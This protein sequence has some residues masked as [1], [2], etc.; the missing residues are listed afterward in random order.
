MNPRFLAL[1]LGQTGALFGAGMTGFALGVWVLAETGSAQRFAW[2]ATATTLPGIVLAPLAGGLAERFAPRDV[3]LLANGVALLATLLLLATLDRG[4]GAATYAILVVSG[5]G[6]GLQWPAYVK[7]TTAVVDARLQA[8]A[9]GLMQIGPLAQ[10]VAAPAAAAVLVVL[11]STGGVLWLDAALLLVAVAASCLVPRAA[12]RTQQATGGLAEAWAFLA[13][14]PALLSLQLFYAASYFFGGTLMALS[15]PYLLALFGAARAGVFLSLAGLGVLVGVAIAAQARWRRV[16]P[17][18]LGLEALGGLCL[19]LLGVT[20]WPAALIVLAA[21]FLAQ[22]TISNALSQTLWQQRVPL[23]LQVRVF[24]LRRMIAWMSLPL[25]YL[26]AGPSADALGVLLH[27]RVDGIAAVLVLGG[28]GKLLVS[29][30][31]RSSQ[32][33]ALDHDAPPT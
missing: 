33:R 20:R 13:A 7:A 2:I 15:T 11:L 29:L 31:W 27:D 6:F 9:A 25:S 14:R 5:V 24:A 23:A 10:H 22:M 12:G 30:A 8:R 16:V 1:L 26:V 3:L 17:S 28:L 32:A 21:T 19:V 18:I 4:L